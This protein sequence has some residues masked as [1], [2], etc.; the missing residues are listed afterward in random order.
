MLCAKRKF[1]TSNFKID[2]KKFIIFTIACLLTVTFTLSAQDKPREIFDYNYVKDGFNGRPSKGKKNTYQDSQAKDNTESTKEDAI[3][4]TSSAE[5][6]SA[7][8]IASK[9]ES[10]DSLNNSLDVTWVSLIVNAMDKQHFHT[11]SLIHI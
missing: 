5:I 8:E 6:K 3:S 11:L 2:M 9:Q 7:S 1:A 10:E 4:A